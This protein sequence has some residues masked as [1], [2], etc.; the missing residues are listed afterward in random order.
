VCTS[1]VIL[2]YMYHDAQA[3][4]VKMAST[5]CVLGRTGLVCEKWSGSERATGYHRRT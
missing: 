1:L 5:P 2:T 4:N 3:E